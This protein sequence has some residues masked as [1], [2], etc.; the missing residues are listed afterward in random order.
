M[1]ARVLAIPALVLAALTAV[2]TAPAH[3]L[4]VD[5]EAPVVVDDS[6][7]MWPG[8]TRDV[9]VLANDTDPA[10]GD[11]AF[12]RVPGPFGPSQGPV[13]LY[14][15][16]VFGDDWGDGL[17]VETSARARGTV[18]ADYY[19][20]NHTHLSPA[21]LTVTIR[22]VQPV[23]VVPARKRDHVRVTNHNDR[24]ITFVAVEPHRCDLDAI[25]RVPAGQQAS[26]EVH[27]PK[28]RWY[29]LIGRGVADTGTVRGIAM[30][31]PVK[32][33]ASPGSSCS[34]SFARQLPGIGAAGS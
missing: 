34:I 6:V 4:E 22:P 7:T 3:A 31:E 19:V 8:E 21:H 1:R 5:P 2:L 25:A 32:S 28:L 24:R 9:D 26:V 27:H 18:V 17:L 12:C 15:P 29:A 30:S 23:D 10:G 20:C 16:A 13:S 11:L 14:D 33:P